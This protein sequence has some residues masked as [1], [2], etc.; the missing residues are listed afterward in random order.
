VDKL[1]AN[2]SSILAFAFQV[3]E[4]KLL[5]VCEYSTGIFWGIENASGSSFVISWFL[6]TNELINFTW[7]DHGGEYGFEVAVFR[8]LHLSWY[9]VEVPIFLVRL[10]VSVGDKIVD[11]EKRNL[12]DW[13]HVVDPGVDKSRA[14]NPKIMNLCEIWLNQVG[15][16]S[17]HESVVEI[18]L[19]LRVKFK[20]SH[21][22]PVFLNVKTCLQA[23]DL[24]WHPVIKLSLCNDQG[25]I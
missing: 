16:V 9:V 3:V 17:M 1:R 22:L 4:N 5:D 18:I 20:F 25:L 24:P 10:P 11:W 6:I 19:R 12:F 13:D 2:N 14:E 7:F 15:I 23:F 8:I 21:C